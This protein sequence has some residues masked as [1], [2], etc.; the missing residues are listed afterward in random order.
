MVFSG[1]QSVR[2]VILVGLGKASE[3]L[4]FSWESCGSRC[5]GAVVCR[6][7]HLYYRAHMASPKHPTSCF[8]AQSRKSKNMQTTS[9]RKKLYFSFPFPPFLSFW[10]LCR[11]CSVTLTLAFSLVQARLAFSSCCVPWFQQTSTPSTFTQQRWVLLEVCWAAW[12]LEIPFVNTQECC[13]LVYGLVKSHL[14]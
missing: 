12:R 6:G 2:P 7:A 1:P 14:T 11:C 10:H 3:W 9:T 8:L 13:L 5:C 4:S